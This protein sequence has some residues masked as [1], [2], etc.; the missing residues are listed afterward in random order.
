[1]RR[2]SAALQPGALPPHLQKLQDEKR[3]QIAAAEAEKAK[4]ENTI[5]AGA[6]SSAPVNISG[7]TSFLDAA[8]PSAKTA[9]RKILPDNDCHG[10]SDDAGASNKPEPSVPDFEWRVGLHHDQGIRFTMEDAESVVTGILP[11]QLGTSDEA[12]PRAC[13]QLAFFGVYDGHGGSAAAEFCREQLPTVVMETVAARMTSAAST[14]AGHDAGVDSDSAAGSSCKSQSPDEALV[15]QALRSA[16]DK[17]DKLFLRKCKE[18]NLGNV[19]TTVTSVLCMGNKLYCANAGDSRTV[20]SRAGKAI[21]LSTDHKPSNLSEEQRVREAGG[22]VLM[23]RV[24][25]KLAVSRA[26]GDSEFKDPESRLLAEFSIS[27]PLVVPEPEVTVTHIAPS[28][29]FLI[30][31]CDGL[32]DIFSSQEAV[33]MVASSLRSGS[34]EEEAAKNLVNTS[35]QRGSRDNVTALVAVLER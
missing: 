11:A 29:E 6:A 25:G 3:A 2:R 17:A 24:M 15:S 32:W 35:L 5:G 22:F 27:S 33:D 4:S 30:L 19:G 10:K 26:I 28:D 16:F 20:L 31:A 23:G 14:A 1:M 9:K 21:D 12:Q 13:P 18:E 8:S 7:A 34:T